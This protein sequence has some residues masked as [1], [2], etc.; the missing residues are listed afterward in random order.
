MAMHPR[1]MAGRKAVA[2]VIRS[3]ATPK[4]SSFCGTFR[5]TALAGVT[6]ASCAAAGPLLPVYGDAT[7]SDYFSLSRPFA[8]RAN[9]GLELTGKACRRSGTT[10]LSPLW[11]RL[12]RVTPMEEV[13]QSTRASLPPIY[14][15]ADQACARYSTV[16]G[17]TFAAGDT[18]RACLDRGHACPT[19]RFERR[20]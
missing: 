18:L 10:L 17:W 19:G 4:K 15:R 14:M 13:S 20:R 1:L 8:Y 7:G 11:V 2:T 3:Q 9:G 12:E 6:L 16:V 5:L